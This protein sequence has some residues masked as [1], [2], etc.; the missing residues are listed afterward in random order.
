MD[1]LSGYK[2]TYG[3]L[4]DTVNQ[5]FPHRI[6]ACDYSDFSF[7]KVPFEQVLSEDELDGD[8]SDDIIDLKQKIHQMQNTLF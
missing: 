6:E 3:I 2:T 7:W 5:I 4:N 1:F 8:G